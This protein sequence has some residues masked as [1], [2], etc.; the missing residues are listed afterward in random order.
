MIVNAGQIGIYASYTGHL[1]CSKRLRLHD[2]GFHFLLRNY[3]KLPVSCV[4]FLYYFL[5]NHC[6]KCLSS[7]VVSLHE[8][9]YSNWTLMTSFWTL[10]Q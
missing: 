1:G 10:K 4:L 6:I 8:I 9:E 3:A 5:Q 7:G 2:V